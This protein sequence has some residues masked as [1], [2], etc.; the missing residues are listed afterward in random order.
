MADEVEENRLQKTQGLEKPEE[1]TKGISYLTTRNVY[2]WGK[3]P[4]QL[5]D[6]I[7]VKEKVKASCKRICFRLKEREITF[8]HQ[9][10]QDKY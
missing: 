3:K 6:C 10:L 8:S 7:S 9:R 2:D 1:R 4:Y 5:G